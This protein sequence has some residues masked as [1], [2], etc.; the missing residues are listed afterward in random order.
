MDNIT[1][2]DINN[3]TWAR[4]T[5][6]KYGP[7]LEYFLKNGSPIEQKLAKKVVE[8]AGMGVHA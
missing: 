7:Q 6:Q 5:K 2:L 3:V 4:E 8:L 1:P